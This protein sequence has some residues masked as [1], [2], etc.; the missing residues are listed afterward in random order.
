[1]RTRRGFTLIELL[2]VIAIIAI[3][4]AMLLP[5]LA[6]AREKA[7]TISCVN[8]CKQ[9]GLGFVM[10]SQDYTDRLA[11]C[12][13]TRPRTANQNLDTQPY[14]RPDS[15]AAT[16]VRYNGYL[17]AYVGDRNSWFCPSGGR[18]ER[19]YAASRQLLQS[20]NG[21]DGRMLAIIR[22]PS[23]HAE[24]GDGIGSRGLCGANR[25]TACQ[26]RWGWGDGTAG[27]LALWQVHNNT[28]NIGFVDGHVETKINPGA[29][30]TVA[31]PECTKMW[32]NPATP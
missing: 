27:Q 4:A 26:G 9:I 3:L 24:F 12:C 32:G 16:D 20:N 23:Q 7:R 13:S 19:S 30:P 18:K 29:F 17:S 25:S 28:A 2:V 1:M 5:A 10:Y 11:I 21:C 22:Y 15:V 8:N 6:K 31:T 14:W